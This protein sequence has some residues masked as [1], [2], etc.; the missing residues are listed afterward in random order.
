MAYTAEELAAVKSQKI[1]MG[2]GNAVSQ[3]RSA[4]GTTLT[5]QGMTLTEINQLIDEMQASIDSAARNSKRSRTLNVLSG[6]GL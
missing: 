6:K 2:S 4:N 1:K 5:Y 3:V